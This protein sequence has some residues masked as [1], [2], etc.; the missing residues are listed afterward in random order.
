M[1]IPTAVHCANH[2][3]V[4]TS[5]RC[6]RCE[7]PI[8]VKCAMRTPTG[9]RCKECVRGQQKIFVTARWHDYLLGFGAAAVGSFLASLLVGA[10][11]MFF[12]GLLVIF[13]APGAGIFIA[14]VV[15]F[16]TRRRRSPALFKTA[17]AGV[18][19]GGLPALLVSA[20]PLFLLFS[21]GSDIGGLLGLLPLIWQGVYIA[22]AV[23]A[24]YFRLSGLRLTT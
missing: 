14:E 6:N 12:F 1:T 24:M 23:P 10:V 3:G 2:P 17:V 19:V 7:K 4:E 21:A 18:I 13:L 8:C 9:Y 5:L 11:S 20:I 16:V 15:R 22:L